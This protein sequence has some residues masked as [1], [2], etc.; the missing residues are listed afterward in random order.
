[1]FTDMAEVSM[2]NSSVYPDIFCLT[3]WKRGWWRRGGLY[4]F[5]MLELDV[6]VRNVQFRRPTWT[7]LSQ[8]LGL[9]DTETIMFLF[10]YSQIT[11]KS[12]A[13]NSNQAKTSGS[14]GLAEQ[15]NVLRVILHYDDT[16]IHLS[17]LW[18][19]ADSKIYSQHHLHSQMSSPS[20]SL[21]LARLSL[22]EKSIAHKI[23]SCNE[24]L[25]LHTK[26]PQEA[27]G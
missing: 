9:R 6:M 24:C 8:I 27:L 13:T 4:C 22:R 18:Q 19:V 16:Y 17:E 15:T 11:N 7:H 23:K 21:H 3:A 25:V 1:M 20:Y 10:H 12:E 14:E 2:S 5:H 26:E